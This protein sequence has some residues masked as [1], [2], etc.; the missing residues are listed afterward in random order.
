[1]DPA[2]YEAWYHT[3]RGAWVSATEFALMR[4]V[5]Q[6]HT[7]EHLLDVGCGTGHFTRRFARLGLQVT[8][9][10]PDP[11]MLAF[12]KSQDEHMTYQPGVA[13]ALP[14]EDAS[15]DQVAAITSLCFSERPEL[16]V[17]EMWRVCRKTL[18]LGLLNRQSW[19]YHQKVNRGGYRGAH[20]DT[21]TT[22][23]SWLAH[24]SPQPQEIVYRSCVFLSGENRIQ[25]L[26]DQFIPTTMPFGAFLLVAANK[27]DG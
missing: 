14:F 27:S 23:T 19:L 8:G 11:A 20:W 16:A 10:D 12:A 26:F 15:F 13:E 9:I 25:R 21:R 4:H 17:Q 6:A 2:D 5:M 3:P 18:L 24:I 22:V 1:M 7:G